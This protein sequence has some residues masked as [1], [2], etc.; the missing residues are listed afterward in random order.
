MRRPSE[1]IEQHIGRLCATDGR[2]GGLPGTDCGVCGKDTVDIVV[3]HL[4]QDFKQSQAY[5]WGAMVKARGSRN[6]VAGR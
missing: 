3:R 2:R 6:S 1:K 5:I 4:H